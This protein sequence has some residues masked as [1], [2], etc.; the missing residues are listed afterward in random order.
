M[1][2]KVCLLLCD[3][4]CVENMEILL[5]VFSKGTLMVPVFLVKWFFPRGNLRGDGWDTNSFK[6]TGAASR[7]NGIFYL[8]Y[9]CLFVLFCFYYRELSNWRVKMCLS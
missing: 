9:S 7:L 4:E 6:T 1:I 5:N 8:L 2:V 3:N